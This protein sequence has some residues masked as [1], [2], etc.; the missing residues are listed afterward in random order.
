MY[1]LFDDP[2]C[3]KG[4]HVLKNKQGI[5][6]FEHLQN[7][8]LVMV[9]FRMEQDLP[10]GNFDKYHLF[11][12]HQYLFQDV[13]PFAGKTRKVRI[14]KDGNPFCFPEYI[15]FQLNQL[16]LKLISLKENKPNCIE[17]FVGELASILADLNAIH[18]FREGNGRA[19]TVFVSMLSSNLGHPWDFEKLDSEAFLQAMVSSFR[20][21]I[22]QLEM[23]IMRL[24][25]N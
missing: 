24:I 14:S 2:N 15:D 5:R 19:Q 18:P 4:T 23:Q 25:S 6:D 22:S 3:Y 12:I 17:E 9:S 10:A 8:E 13:Y 1:D 16:D 7:F 21:D 20:G 11:K